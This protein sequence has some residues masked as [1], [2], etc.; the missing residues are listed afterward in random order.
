MDR[1][2]KEELKRALEDNKS[3]N[4]K[5]WDGKVKSDNLIRSCAML[6]F[7]IGLIIGVIIDYMI[8]K[9]ITNWL[10]GLSGFTQLFAGIGAVIGYMFIVVLTVVITAIIVFLVAAFTIGKN[11][12]ESDDYTEK[13]I[14]DIMK[15]NGSSGK[16]FEVLGEL[17]SV[18]SDGTVA[19]KS[20]NSDRLLIT[21]AIKDSDDLTNGLNDLDSGKINIR[22]RVYITGK[23][24]YGLVGVRED[25]IKSSI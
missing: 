3:Y 24:K 1:H 22:L 6:S 2:S 20:L 11:T 18:D 9:N 4:R 10:K 5:E 17:Y 25:I 16:R 19:I 8:Q 14:D 7:I 23:C 12:L 15:I 13:S 21:S